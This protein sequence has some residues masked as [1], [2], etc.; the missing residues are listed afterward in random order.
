MKFI[1][2][3][4]QF[5]TAY[6]V[7]NT[8]GKTTQ[9]EVEKILDLAWKNNISFL[10]TAPAYEDSEKSLGFSA[11]NKDWGIIT[12]TPHFEQK[13]ISNNQI[14]FLEEVFRSSL[15]NLNRNSVECLMVHACDDLFKPGGD[16]IIRTLEKLKEQSHINKIG[17]SVYNKH[18][19]DKVLDNFEIDIIQLPVSV[20]D[21]RLIND[22]SLTKLKKY[23]VEIH[24]RS[25]FLQ[26]LLL[27]SKESIPDYFLPIFPNLNKLKAK[28]N[29][30]SVSVLELA[31][32]F[33]ANIENIDYAVI[34]VNSLKQLQQ[35]LS[36]SLIN[37]DLDNFYEVSV[38]DDKFVN[39][40]NW[41]FE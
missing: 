21:Q 33:I 6:G 32:S 25:I 4:V 28:S 1:L 7:S 37:L 30:L 31:L 3:T 41:F 22:G 29:E 24:A 5:G 17:I 13:I 27:M 12:K 19:I 36:S 10:D 38:A 9:T 15:S 34:G 23:G 20:L 16:K 35:I 11:V 2:G 18:Q 39:P 26:G 14:H 40:S 8:K